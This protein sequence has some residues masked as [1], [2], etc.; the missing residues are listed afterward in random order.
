MKRLY[1]LS[2]AFKVHSIT[3]WV[4]QLEINP[5]FSI[6]NNIYFSMYI[7]IFAFSSMTSQDSE[8]SFHI[9]K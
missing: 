4:E 8:R 1:L 2:L 6:Q 7:D 9:M 3:A 5:L